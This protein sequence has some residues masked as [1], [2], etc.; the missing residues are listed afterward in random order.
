MISYLHNPCAITGTFIIY[1]AFKEKKY[2]PIIWGKQD[3]SPPTHFLKKGGTSQIPGNCWGARLK[4]TAW[5]N[6]CAVWILALQASHWFCFISW[7]MEQKK[8]SY[9]KTMGNRFRALWS[10]LPWKKIQWEFEYATQNDRVCWRTVDK[11]PEL[12]VGDML[13]QSWINFF[14]TSSSGTIQ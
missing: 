13:K 8:G 7:K 11:L 3:F 6:T 4:N 12:N 14:T 2:F 9:E 5:W 1:S 10:D